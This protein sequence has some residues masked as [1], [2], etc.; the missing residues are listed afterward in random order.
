LFSIFL[1]ALLA[2]ELIVNFT[3]ILR[4]RWGTCLTFFPEFRQSPDICLPKKDPKL[5]GTSTY[6]GL[7]HGGQVIKFDP[8][9]VGLKFTRKFQVIDTCNK[10]SKSLHV[11]NRKS[12]F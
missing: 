12:K 5:I 9:G 10:I 6:P 8:F 7:R 3:L 1:N 2:G 4:R 11:V